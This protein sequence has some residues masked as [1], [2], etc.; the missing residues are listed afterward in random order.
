M[1]ARIKLYDSHLGH[2]YE[3]RRIMLGLH[4][5]VSIFPKQ[6]PLWTDLVGLPKSFCKLMQVLI[7]CLYEGWSFL[8]APFLDKSVVCSSSELQCEELA[9]EGH[10]NTTDE[11]LNFRL[12]FFSFH[13]VLYDYLLLLKLLSNFYVFYRRI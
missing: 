10:R 6:R 5:N 13:M 2:L 7:S 11:T 9:L 12:F 1:K 8:V 4:S 3:L